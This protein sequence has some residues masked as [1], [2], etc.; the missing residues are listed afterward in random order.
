MVQI[1]RY[2]TIKKDTLLIE[3]NKVPTQALFILKGYTRAYYIDDN[4]REHT[5]HFDWENDMVI[6]LRCFFRGKPAP[7]SQVA[8]E[9]LE[10]VYTT[11]DELH[12][13]FKRHPRFETTIREM[14]LDFLPDLSEHT[15]MLQMIS[16]Q[17]RYE[18]FVATRP[19]IIKRV[20]QKYIASYLG[21][22][23]E[24]LSRVRAKRD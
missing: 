3:Q 22:T 20:P 15:K 17:E 19:D 9:Q 23:T 21:M 14:I 1:T 8:M 11:Y 24:T 5:S 7:Y 4:G 2:G 13:F 12:A 6:P 16:A 10:V 18:Y